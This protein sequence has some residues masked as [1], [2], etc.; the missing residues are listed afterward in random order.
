MC[1]HGIAI[2]MTGAA[3]GR[4]IKQTARRKLLPVRPCPVTAMQQ[5]TQTVQRQGAVYMHQNF[6]QYTC[7]T[8]LKSRHC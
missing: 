8:R 6:L 2:A 5:G 4:H 3:L 1:A 7:H